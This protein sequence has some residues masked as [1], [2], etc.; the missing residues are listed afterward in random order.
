MVALALGAD[1]VAVGFQFAHAGYLRD[2]Q[3][4]RDLGS[5]L[6]GF[7]VQRILAEQY[8]VERLALEPDRERARRRE[9]VGAGK[10]PIFEMHCAID[11]HRK[12]LDQRGPGLRRPHRDRHRFGAETLLQ[13]DRERDRAQVEGADHGRSVAADGLR[14]RIEVDVLDERNLLDTNGNFTHEKQAS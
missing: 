7:S 10:C 3:Q 8:Q 12:R 5:D 14:D 11:S 1:R 4:L 9:R 13:I 2:T 6:P